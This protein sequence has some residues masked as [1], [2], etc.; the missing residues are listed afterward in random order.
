MRRPT[1]QQ[2][3]YH[4]T[5]FGTGQGQGVGFNQLPTS[6]RGRRS[7]IANTY[8]QAKPFT[9][10]KPGRQITGAWMDRYI[11][12]RVSVNLCD[13]CARIYG[14]WL[15]KPKYDYRP[16]TAHS[17]LGDCD[18]C[19]GTGRPERLISYYPSEYYQERKLKPNQKLIIKGVS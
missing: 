10:T 5:R 16:Q 3:N 8:S 7:V 11:A 4:K 1:Q 18:G 15:M 2:I 6:I 12:N 17:K 13:V 9:T 14:P 19:G